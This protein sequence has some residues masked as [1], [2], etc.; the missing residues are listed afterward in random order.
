MTTNDDD[1]SLTFHSASTSYESPVFK[2]SAYLKY[3]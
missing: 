2:L 3:N 1:L